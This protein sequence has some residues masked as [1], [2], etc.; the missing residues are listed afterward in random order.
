MRAAREAGYKA[1]RIETPKANRI[2]PSQSHGGSEKKS[3]NDAFC[4]F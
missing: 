2:A 1:A 3:M 4:G